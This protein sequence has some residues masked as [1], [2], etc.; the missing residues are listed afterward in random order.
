MQGGHVALRTMAAW[1]VWDR[2]KVGTELRGDV[3]GD[4]AGFTLYRLPKI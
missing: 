1:S 4:K 3:G 2:Q